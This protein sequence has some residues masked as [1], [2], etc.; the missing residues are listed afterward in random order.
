M[1]NDTPNPLN[2]KSFFDKLKFRVTTFADMSKTA[3][4]KYKQYATKLL[5]RNVSGNDVMNDS[6]RLITSIRPQDIGKMIMYYYDPK[7]KDKLPYYDRFPLVIPLEIYK[8]GFLGL[9]LHY[10]PPEYR[11]RLMDSLYA[12][13]YPKKNTITD[14]KKIAITYRL[15][16]QVSR[17]RLFEPCVK[18]YLYTHLRSRLFVVPPEDWDVAI[19]LPTQRFN[20][21]NDAT[22]WASSLQ[23]TRGR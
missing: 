5:K 23:K 4:Q 22:V 17:N 18:R 8:D 13:V 21:A 20:K 14:S 11:A 3:L 2:S 16:A 19:F 7:L 1:E 6:S 9:N 15:L 12:S 10:L